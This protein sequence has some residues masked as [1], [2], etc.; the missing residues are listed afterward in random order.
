MVSGLVLKNLNL[1]FFVIRRGY[2]TALHGSSSFYLTVPP[3]MLDESN[4][5]L[6]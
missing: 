4:A 2:G 3:T 1:E 5:C 6:K